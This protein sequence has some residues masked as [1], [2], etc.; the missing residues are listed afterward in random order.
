MTAS[1]RLKPARLMAAERALRVRYRSPVGVGA[2]PRLHRIHTGRRA[3]Y[4]VDFHQCEIDSDWQNRSIGSVSEKG[5][6]VKR[7]CGR[8]LVA[9]L[10]LGVGLPQLAA[11]QSG[12]SERTRK[13][14]EVAMQGEAFEYLLYRSYANWA[15]LSGFPELAKTF[16]DVAEAEG[17]DHFAREAA[18]YGLIHSNVENL[19]SAM[20]NESEEQISFNLKYAEE[21][22]KAGDTKVAAMFRDIAAEEKVHFD[23]LKKAMD[24]LKKDTAGNMGSPPLK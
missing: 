10:L 4:A 20:K 3:P 8:Y 24:D 9:M 17:K 13:N 6:I 18:A 11:A 7:I 16:R 15:E 22:S 12:V 14:L 2:G 21:A 1:W 19:Q 5:N 23:R